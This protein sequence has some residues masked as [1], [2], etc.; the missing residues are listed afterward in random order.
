MSAVVT[1]AGILSLSPWP[2]SQH[3]VIHQPW[4]PDS[5]S[6]QCRVNIGELRDR[7]ADEL[8]EVPRRQ[9][10]EL[11]KSGK[12]LRPSIDFC[13]SLFCRSVGTDRK[14][15]CCTLIW[16][17]GLCVAVVF[18]WPAN[19]KPFLASNPR[20]A[21]PGLVG[22]SASYGLLPEHVFVNYAPIP[23]QEFTGDALYKNLLLWVQPNSNR[24]IALTHNKHSFRSANLPFINRGDGHKVGRADKFVLNMNAYHYSRSAPPIIQNIYE[25]L[26]WERRR[27]GVFLNLHSQ[28]RS[29]S[30][31]YRFGIKKSSFGSIS[32]VRDAVPRSLSSLGSLSGLF[33]DGQQS[34]N[35]G[36]CCRP[37]WPSEKAI[38]TWSVPFGI[39]YVLL[40]M[41]FIRFS[42][43]SLFVRCCGWCCGII[44]GAFILTGYVNCQPQNHNKRSDVFDHS[45]K[46]VAVQVIITDTQALAASKHDLSILHEQQ[47]W[48]LESYVRDRSCTTLQIA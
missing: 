32:L 21:P 16:I 20:I 11:S 17:L 6:S 10:L 45:H 36:P 2:R 35:Y 44:G 29:L 25:I 28:P 15:C 22:L 23:H 46:I 47:E 8:R 43:D 24:E 41:I 12:G 18:F 19:R 39:A 5:L 33:S 40:G 1:A 30:I 31:D 14:P 4:F 7:N 27:V 37:V 38:P 42:S 26:N 3:Q 34:Q 9:F 48:C 13:K